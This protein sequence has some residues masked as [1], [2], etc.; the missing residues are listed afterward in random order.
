MMFK[1]RYRQKPL[2]MRSCTPDTS[3]IFNQSISS[4]LHLFSSRYLSP[5]PP[6]PLALLLMRPLC[7]VP[8]LFVLEPSLTSPP[9]TVEDLKSSVISHCLIDQSI[10]YIFLVAVPPARLSLI[11]L[12]V[13][14]VNILSSHLK[15]SSLNRTDARMIHGFNCPTCPVL[16]PAKVKLKQSRL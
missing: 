10:W 3:C 14:Q 8:D 7:A 9:L 12:Y 5:Y 15:V 4:F 6:P 13:A 16:R 11:L 2:E 1:L